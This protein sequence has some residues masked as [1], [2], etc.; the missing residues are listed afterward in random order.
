M[1]IVAQYSSVMGIEG[2]R[3]IP[4]NA[5]HRRIARYSSQEDPL[6]ISVSGRICEMAAEAPITIHIRSR[7]RKTSSTLSDPVR[8]HFDILIP[9]QHLPPNRSGQI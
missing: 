9:F 6:Y 4:M 2:E 8:R 7:P 3:Q 1:Q 5:D